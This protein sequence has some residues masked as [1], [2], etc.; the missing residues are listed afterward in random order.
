MRSSRVSIRKTNLKILSSAASGHH[1]AYLET[2]VKNK[3][4]GDTYYYSFLNCIQYI[5]F[6]RGTI[7]FSDIYKRIQSML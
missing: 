4:A 5:Y 7:N 2:T 1:E 6:E 3:R